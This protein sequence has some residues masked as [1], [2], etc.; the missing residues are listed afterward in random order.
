MTYALYIED[1][2]LNNI[3]CMFVTDIDDNGVRY[4]KSVSYLSESVRLSINTL[5]K[6]QQCSKSAYSLYIALLYKLCNN[7]NV[8]NIDTKALKS[9]L[10]YSDSVISRAKV[11]LKN[12]G[13]IEISK[14]YK[15]TYIIPIDTAYKGNLNKMIEKHKERKAELER[16]ELEEKERNSINFLNIKRKSKIKHNESKNQKT[17]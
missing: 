2:T 8:I 4:A 5:I 3:D 15:D 17:E 10:G 14:E 6:L 13:L 1:D 11:E 9:I 16:L 7:T 12:A